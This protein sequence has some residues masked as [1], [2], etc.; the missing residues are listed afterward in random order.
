MSIY[1][2]FVGSYIQEGHEYL[3]N[4]RAKSLS[5]LISRIEGSQPF[6]VWIESIKE[7]P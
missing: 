5:D 3:F 4:M 2:T 1:K 7:L 6:A